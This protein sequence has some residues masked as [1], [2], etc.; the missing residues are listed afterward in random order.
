MVLRV[1]GSAVGWMGQLKDC[2]FFFDGWVSCEIV[3]SMG[4]LVVRLFC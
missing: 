3:L 1:T 4:V 2:F